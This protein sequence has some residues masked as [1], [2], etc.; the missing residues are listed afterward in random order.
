M[1]VSF[2][3]VDLISRGHIFQTV[4]AFKQLPQL[5][6]FSRNIA[7]ALLVVDLVDL[8]SRETREKKIEMCVSFLKVD[9]I[10][11]GPSS[12]DSLGIQYVRFCWLTW[13][14]CFLEK[15]ESNFFSKC[16]L[17]L[18]VDITSRGKNFQ[19]VSAFNHLLQLYLF[20]VNPNPSLS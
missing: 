15:I 16:V 11:R 12:R 2:L 19:T 5:Q 13:L 3:K 6:I 20:I 18:K 7:C 10:S 9:L 17:F 4:F 1:C 14:T 8:L